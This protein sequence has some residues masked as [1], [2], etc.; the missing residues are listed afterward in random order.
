MLVK[1][2]VEAKAAMHSECQQRQCESWSLCQGRLAMGLIPLVLGPSSGKGGEWR[3][4]THNVQLH[5]AFKGSSKGRQQ[6]QQTQTVELLG[7][8]KWNLNQ[9]DDEEHWAKE[10]KGTISTV[11]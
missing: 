9:E 2:Y 10:D 6:Q 3:M 7:N 1:N 5:G 8:L 4:E 11:Q